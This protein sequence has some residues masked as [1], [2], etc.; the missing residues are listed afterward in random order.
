MGAAGQRLGAQQQFGGLLGQQ[1]QQMYGAGTQLGQTMGQLGQQAMQARMG[2]GQAGLGTAGQ[3]AQGYGQLGGVQGQV[4]Q[5]V[6]Q[7]MQGYG[8]QLQGLGGQ[9]AQA[10]QQDVASLMGMGSQQQQLRQRQLDAQ[11]AGL[12][13]AQ[14]AP[15]AQYQQLMPFM[16]FAAGQTGPSGV[17]T[18]YTP[19]PSPLQAGLGAGLSALGAMGNFFNQQQAAYPYPYQQ[20]PQQQTGG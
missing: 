17:T 19:P 10:G 5:Q 14:Q 9:F 11:R 18:Q 8:Q 20:P 13:Q 1:A 6:G 3:L 12:L 2:A 15:L 7:A 16:Q 4:G